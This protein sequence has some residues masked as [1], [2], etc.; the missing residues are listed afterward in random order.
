M[1]LPIVL[2]SSSQSRK[3]VLKGHLNFTTVSPNIDEK[4]IRHQDPSVLTLLIANAKMAAIE[5]KCPNSIVICLD[6][7]VVVNGNI[8][9]KPETKEE[10]KQFINLYSKYPAIC[11]SG[12]VV[13]NTESGEKR[14]CNVTA[15]QAFKE[16][17][18]PDN[19]IDQIVEKGNYSN[20]LA[21]DSLYPASYKTKVICPV[22]WLA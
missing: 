19:V 13:K 20:L 18:I 6:Q 22:G 3:D 9:E 10:A 2:G 5:A 17:K 21:Y 16:S 14:Q 1:P 4:S 15:T 11:I 7:V 8:L 12:L